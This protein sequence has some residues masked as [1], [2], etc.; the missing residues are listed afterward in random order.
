M[1]TVLIL[2]G[3]GLVGT[4]IIKEMSKYRSIDVYSTYFQNRAAF[5]QN[6]SFQFNV[7]NPDN[8]NDLLNTLK[9][10]LIVSCLRGDFHKQLI[11]HRK[12]AEYLEQNGGN[13]YFFSTA[14]VFDNDLSKPHFEEEL[15]NS[16]TDY[17][18]YKIE[19]EN[20]LKEILHD[21]VCILRIPQIWGKNSPRM[22][23]MLTLRH[24]NE[25]I[26]VYPKFFH[27]TNTDVM[28]AKQLC[29]IISNDLKGTF[30]LTSDD[31]VNYED[32]YT[33]LM[34]GVGLDHSRL[35]ENFEE[36]GYFALLS[37]R[38]KEFPESLRY[39]NQ[40]VIH[41]LLNEYDKA[42]IAY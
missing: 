19:C 11:V 5:H 3:S 35:Q 21:H 30:H 7:E 10:N 16:H 28:L 8:I 20:K 26:T 24:N 25:K 33:E 6:E 37:E 39:T 9:P 38:S 17:G 15:P 4:A 23:Q 32:F 2:G 29:H 22:Q 31:I 40:S 18:R 34:K 41:Y 13:L 1:N 12:A 36:E 42:N 14:N 27:N